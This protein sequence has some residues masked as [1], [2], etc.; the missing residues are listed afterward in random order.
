MAEFNLMQALDR[1]NSIR[2]KYIHLFEFDVAL[3]SN[4]T[5][6]MQSSFSKAMLEL[7]LLKSHFG[8]SF[9]NA[10]DRDLSVVGELID[11]LLTELGKQES[12]YWLALA[13]VHVQYGTSSSAHL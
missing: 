3:M 9:S 2:T 12:K 5:H 11:L 7:G 4:T 13:L 6:Q 8:Q 10:S 1:V